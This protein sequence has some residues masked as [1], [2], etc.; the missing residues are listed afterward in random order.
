MHI[1]AK[2]SLL[3]DFFITKYKTFVSCETEILA[4]K[5]LC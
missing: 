2:V 3:K 5:I 4:Y 1:C